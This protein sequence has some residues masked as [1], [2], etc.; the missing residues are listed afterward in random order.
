M[1]PQ[2]VRTREYEFGILLDERR[3]YWVLFSVG[4]LKGVV[5]I[6]EMQGRKSGRSGG[7]MGADGEEDGVAIGAVKY[8][9]ES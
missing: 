7:E 8:L 6:A 9:G 2:G 3:E 4:Q 5:R 1:A